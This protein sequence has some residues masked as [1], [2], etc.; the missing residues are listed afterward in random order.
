MKHLLL[1]VLL[2]TSC[3]HS[4]DKNAFFQDIHEEISNG[5]RT[6]RIDV[7]AEEDHPVRKDMCC[8]DLSCFMKDGTELPNWGLY[9]YILSGWKDPTLTDQINH[10]LFNEPLPK[11][12]EEQFVVHFKTPDPPPYEWPIEAHIQW[13]YGRYLL[14]KGYYND[15]VCRWTIFWQEPEGAV[16]DSSGN[17]QTK[18][19]HELEYIEF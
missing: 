19:W 15:V 9:H 10:H 11:I 2:L 8:V 3:S 6:V 14:E 16:L 17:W 18:Y 1:L 4:T 5:V 12:E 13:E 7:A